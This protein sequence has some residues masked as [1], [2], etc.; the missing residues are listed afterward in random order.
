MRVLVAGELNPDLVLASLT[1]APRPGREVVARDCALRLGSS[2]AI[3]AA[4]LAALGNE[5]AFLGIVG[6]DMFGRFCIEQLSTAGVDVALVRAD[7]TLR[8][9]VTVSI[10]GRDR[11]L[12]TYP[13]AMEQWRA[14]EATDGLLA[15]FCHLHVSAYFLQRELRA[16]LPDLFRRARSLGLSTSLDPGHDPFEEWGGGF[17]R[18]SG[19]RAS[20]S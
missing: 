12:V 10:S 9:G 19:K 11:A 18:P 15:R 4:G 2:S 8:T 1:G 14:E 3:C 20:C 16:C 6:D 13:G 17:A 7:P 5:V